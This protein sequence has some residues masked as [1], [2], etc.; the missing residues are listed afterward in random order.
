ML[1][2]ALIDDSYPI[3]TRNEKILNSLAAHY[4]EEVK[5]SVITWD[6]SNRYTG[7]IPGYYV[8]KRDSAY[9]NKTRKLL[10]LWGYRRFCH[11]TIHWLKPDVVIASHWNNLLSV[12]RLD[13]SRQMFI[14][15]NLDVPTEAYLLRKASTLLEHWYLR[16]VDLIIHA[17]RFFRQLY[18]PRIPQIVLENKPAMATEPQEHCLHHPIRIAYIG[19]LRYIDMLRRLVDAVRGE[20]RIQLFF[21]GGGHALEKLKEYADGEDNIV[22]TGYYQYEQIT[23]LYRQTDIV[24]AAY[25]NK[26]FNVKYAISNKFH[27]SLAFTVPA[28]YSEQT[29]LG[30]F[31]ERHGIGIT[32]NPNS[33]EDIRKRL[34]EVCNGAYDMGKMQQRLLEF[35]QKQTTWDEDFLQVVN[36]IDH[37][38]KP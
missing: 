9:G 26:D 22:F 16:R 23:E 33:A 8:Y 30:D 12:P 19:A 18:S 25:P 20:E 14:Y 15:E 24:W 36:A 34:L 4:G 1:H 29:R 10:N 21:H 6:R 3:N 17:S 11:E 37:F 2:I 27:E 13:R 38:R 7:D 32:I 35:Q 28:I 5:L 31:V